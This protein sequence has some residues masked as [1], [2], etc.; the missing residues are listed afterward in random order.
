M[1]GAPSHL[2]LFDYKPE[3]VKHNGEPCP[4]EFI[5]GKRFA[6]IR[7]HPRLLGSKFKFA[8]YGQNGVELSELLPQLS[9]VAD[10][11]C[12]VKT[13]RTDEFNHGPAQLFLHTGFGRLG[14]PSFGSWLTYGL[15]SENQDL[16]AYVG[17]AHRRDH[18]QA[19]AA[20]S[21]A[22]ASCRAFIRACNSGRAATRCCSCRIPR[23]TR[24]P[25]A[26]ACWMRS[27]S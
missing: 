5:E 17:H 9:Q 25:T 8:K 22:T 2:D 3:L 27:M 16:P 10:D 18:G 23:A 7:G 4:K 14:R 11:L 24:P 13:V 1:V 26:A 12:V 21:G 20:A 15:G 19:R 6:F